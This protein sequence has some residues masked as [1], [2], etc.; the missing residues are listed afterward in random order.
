MRSY[1]SKP[2]FLGPKFFCYQKVFKTNHYNFWPTK[3]CG[4]TCAIIFYIMQLGYWIFLRH[5]T[6]YLRVYSWNFIYPVYLTLISQ[7]YSKMAKYAMLCH[8]EEFVRSVFFIISVTVFGQHFLTN[9]FN[10][11]NTQRIDVTTMVCSEMSLEQKSS[12]VIS[13]PDNFFLELLVSRVSCLVKVTIL[14]SKILN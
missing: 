13:L 5:L 6:N 3:I 1:I 10:V 8:T 12:M 4:I 7:G 9:Q 14:S 11:G 2:T